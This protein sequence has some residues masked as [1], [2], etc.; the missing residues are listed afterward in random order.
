MSKALAPL[1][2]WRARF[3]GA[4]ATSVRVLVD[5]GAST[6]PRLAEAMEHALLAPGKR[7]RPLIVLAA[8]Q[9]SLAAR[10][11]DAGDEALFP[12][13]LPPALAVE[14]VHAYSLVHDDLPGMDDDDLRRGRPTVHVAFDESTAILA[15]DALLT[16]AFAH[17]AAA[18]H[19][20][21][22]QVRELALAAGSAGMVGGQHDDTRPLVAGQPRTLAELEHIHARKTGCLFRAA[23]RLGALAVDDQAS[24]AALGRYGQRL[25]L[26]FQIGDDILDVTAD[27]ARAGKRLGR[28]EAKITFV[29]LLGVD[30]ARRR[31]Q[32]AAEEAAEAIAALGAP[33]LV[34]LARFAAARDH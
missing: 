30:E 4:L 17:L 14:H 28:D 2:P 27:P 26:A 3:E 22:A 7:L 33:L 21:A 20:P 15:G 13:C 19:H 1:H 23:A 16:N 10:G 29:T 25:G 11:L 24:V 32:A 5:D 9:A 12:L 31:A 8:G 18:T 34:E 6:P